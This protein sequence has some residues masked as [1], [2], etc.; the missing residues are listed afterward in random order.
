MIVKLQLQKNNLENV[1]CGSVQ[2]SA[3]PVVRCIRSVDLIY[4]MVT[5][6]YNTVMYN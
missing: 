5:I 3:E 4:N 1:E 2:E 6:T